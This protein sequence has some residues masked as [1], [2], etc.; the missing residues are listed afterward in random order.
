MDEERDYS[1][2]GDDKDDNSGTKGK[3]AEKPESVKVP[4]STLPKEI[5]VIIPTDSIET[6][7]LTH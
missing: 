4:E 6:C 5:Q 1:D 3:A 7:Q 2:E